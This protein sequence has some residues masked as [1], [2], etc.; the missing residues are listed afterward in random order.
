MPELPE[1]ETTVRG[2]ARYLDGERLA[3]VETRR[4]DLR[5]PF[6]PDLVQVL[7]GATVTGLS[8]RAKYGLIH[9]DRRQTM[10]FHLGMS[11]R[12]RIDPDEL[13]KHDHLVL[14]TG[15]SHLLALCDPRRFGSVD[16]VPTEGLDS[17]APFAAMGPE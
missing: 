8:R 10:V 4:G 14:E 7:T 9:T 6:P 17:W 3:R 5:R 15:S 16:L 11:G 12:W 2:L 1:V 13:G